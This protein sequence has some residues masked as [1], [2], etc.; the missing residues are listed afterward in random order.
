MFHEIVW[1]RFVRLPFGHVLDY[2]GKNGEAYYP[3]AEECEKSIPDPRS[4]VFL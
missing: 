3:T 4:W 2:A 1:N